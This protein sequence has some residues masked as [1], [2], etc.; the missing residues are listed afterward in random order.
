LI[1][2]DIV[3]LFAEMAFVLENI[4][5]LLLYFLRDKVVPQLKLWWHTSDI[6][7]PNQLAPQPHHK[8]T[9]P[10]PQPYHNHTTT[11]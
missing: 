2:H 4:S 3:E 8:H 7:H 6:L 5:V 10:T 11:V 1:T 9:T